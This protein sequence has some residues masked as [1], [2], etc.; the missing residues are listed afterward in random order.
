ML[1]VCDTCRSYGENI[2]PVEVVSGRCSS[3]SERP[4]TGVRGGAWQDAARRDR[5]SRGPFP[6]EALALS[7]SSIRPVCCC[8][9]G[10]S[11]SFRCSCRVLQVGTQA[12]LLTFCVA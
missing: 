8:A 4:G 5:P 1:L 10:F 12:G 2:K 7:L 6:G 9:G 3:A 11:T